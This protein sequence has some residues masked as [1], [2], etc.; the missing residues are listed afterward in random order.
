[1]S[2]L[3]GTGLVVQE[4]R[5]GKPFVTTPPLILPRA[6]VQ[7]PDREALQ[8]RIE[9][10]PIRNE[11]NRK[12]WL[13]SGRSCTTATNTMTECTDG[14]IP[15]SLETHQV[16]FV[17]VYGFTFEFHSL[18]QVKEYLSIFS[19]YFTMVPRR[20]RPLDGL[21]VRGAGPGFTAWT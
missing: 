10:S 2:N 16:N 3:F 19:R 15:S 8:W 12:Q 21:F 11:W 4:G 1:M 20:R 5:S 14:T 9:R 7:W 18:A 13:V 6:D 17:Q